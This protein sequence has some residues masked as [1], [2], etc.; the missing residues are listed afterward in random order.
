MKEVSRRYKNAMKK[1]IR[2]RSHCV[3]T[4]GNTDITAITDGVWD[5]EAS[6]QSSY[7]TI[8]YEHRYGNTEAFLELNRW[9]LDGKTIIGSNGYND[10]FIGEYVDSGLIAKTF[11]YNHALSGVTLTFDTRMNEY[12][13]EV[14]IYYCDTTLSE[15]IVDHNGN[16]II[17][18]SGEDIVSFVIGSGSSI[19]QQKIVYPTSNSIPIEIPSTEVNTIIIAF[20]SMLPNRRARLEKVTWGVSAIW[21]DDQLVSVKQN[22][23][24]DPLSRRLPS[25]KMDVTIFDYQHLYDPDNPQ[26]IYNYINK[27]TPITVSYGMELDDGTIEWT[28]PDK[29]SLLNTPSW[30]NERVTFNAVGLIQTLTGMYY[31]GSYVS[32]GKTLYALATEILEDA[33]DNGYLQPLDDGNNPWDIDDSLEEMWTQ[34]IPPIETYANLLQV[35]AHASCSRLFTDDDN[36]IHIKPFGVTPTG[37]FEGTYTDDG[38]LS[39]SEWDSVDYGAGNAKTM[40]TLEL[41]RFVLDGTNT[42]EVQ[43]EGFISS[44]GSQSIFGKVFDVTH[45]LPLVNLTF[46]TVMG[47]YPA[48]LKAEYLRNGQIIATQYA[49]PTESEHTIHT[50]TA[51]D[52]DTIRITAKPTLPNTRI[53]LSKVSFRETDFALTLEDTKENQSNVSKIEKLRNVVVNT[54]H[55]EQQ[56]QSNIYEKTITLS[57]RKVVHIE[58]GTAINIVDASTYVGTPY[59]KNIYAQAADIDLPAGTH[60]ILLKG[61]PLQRNAEEVMFPVNSTGDDDIETN[62]IIDTQERTTALGNHVKEYLQLR[63]TYD[64]G[65]RGNPELE[66]GDIIELQTLYSQVVY[67]LVLVDEIT[68]NG[69]LSGKVKVKGII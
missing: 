26:G 66:V 68:Y 30:K 50:E 33:M 53:R 12:P 69:A 60:S 52:C 29:Y 35:I 8:D 20:S 58:Y 54:Y 67:G 39:I 62:P 27:G 31:K 47:D 41:N 7:D 10:G 32:S 34:W 19:L 13:F 49:Y 2:N 43:S 36:I 55:Y 57:E 63:N 16:V 15:E 44:N 1:T 42:T 18:D 48:E 6:P 17:T 22:H 9:A 64:E 37:I 24:V 65:Y 21:N 45:D 4:F 38:H 28:K 61:N 14:T 40:A 51:Y 56:Q 59:S 5:G 23:D 3:V 11:S 46:D 25:E